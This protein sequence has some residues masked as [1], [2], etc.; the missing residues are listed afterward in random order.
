MALIYAPIYRWYKHSYLFD[1]AFEKVFREVIRDFDRDHTMW[2]IDSLSDLGELW[3]EASRFHRY[4][5]LSWIGIKP[6]NPYAKKSWDNIPTDI[7]HKLFPVYLAKKRENDRHVESVINAFTKDKEK[8]RETS[9]RE[10]CRTV[11]CETAGSKNDIFYSSISYI[12]RY[13]TK[14]FEHTGNKEY[15]FLLYNLLAGLCREF[16]IET[17]AS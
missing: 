5:M 14:K 7:R 11:G 9:Y 8:I 4:V 1:T 3:N 16:G 15:E 2:C 6:P 13:Y 12:S 10:I 17:L